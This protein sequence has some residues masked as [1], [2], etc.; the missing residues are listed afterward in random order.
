MIT[1]LLFSF[2]TAWMPSLSNYWEAV[3]FWQ[4]VLASAILWEEEQE[5]IT[6][7]AGSPKI[8]WEEE[9]EKITGRLVRRRLVVG[10]NK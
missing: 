4:S 9:Q 10:S 6:V 3:S 5:K 7:K 2:K 1:Y 8:L